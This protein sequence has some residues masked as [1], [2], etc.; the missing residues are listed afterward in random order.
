MRLRQLL[1]CKFESSGAIFRRGQYPASYFLR[2]L[3]TRLYHRALLVCQQP[4]RDSPT[5]CSHEDD[6]P[7]TAP[8]F[9]CGCDL[10]V[11]V[12]PEMQHTLILVQRTRNNAIRRHRLPLTAACVRDAQPHMH[13]AV[14]S[15]NQAE[16]AATIDE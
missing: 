10:V 3:D 11:R 5:Q 8:C 7:S 12:E 15:P 1:C 4:I 16:R 6:L 2:Q 9:N 14:S 13:T